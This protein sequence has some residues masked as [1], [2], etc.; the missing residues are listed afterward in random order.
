LENCVFR[1]ACVTQFLLLALITGTIYLRYCR[2]WFPGVS[3]RRTLLHGNQQQPQQQQQQQHRTIKAYQ[4]PSTRTIIVMPNQ[5]NTLASKQSTY[6]ASSRKKI[7]FSNISTVFWNQ[8][9][10]PIVTFK[11]CSL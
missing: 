1:G 3:W 9:I 6:L 2:I 7:L 11:S 5:K 4:R 8:S 10:Y